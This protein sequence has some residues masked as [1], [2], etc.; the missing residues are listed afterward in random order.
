MDG[1]GLIGGEGKLGFIAL[2]RKRE[3]GVK[4]GRREKVIYFSISLIFLFD[5]VRKRVDGSG[6]GLDRVDW[7]SS[8]WAWIDFG[9]WVLVK[10]SG[11]DFI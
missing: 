9:L 7:I 11:P 8:C 4:I 2:G 10:D 1:I 3:Y 6:L 5:R